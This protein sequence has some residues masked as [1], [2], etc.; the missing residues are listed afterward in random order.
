[1]TPRDLYLQEKRRAASGL[2]GVGAISIIASFCLL[3]VPLYLFQVYDRVLTS[4]S[5]ET[6]LALTVIVSVLLI[7]YGILDFIRQII[8]ARIA[9]RFETG[10]AGIV[11]AGEL[12]DE[13]G[14][15]PSILS[16]VSDIRRLMASRVFPSLF[17]LP[18]VFLFLLIVFAIHFSLGLIVLAGI[19]V[20]VVLTLLG[21]GISAGAVAKMQQSGLASRRALEDVA[22]Q[23]EVIRAMGMYRPAISA[24]GSV[25]TPHLKDSLVLQARADSV[26]AASRMARQLI[27][28]AMIGGGA[29]LVLGDEVTP[30]IIFATSVVASRALAPIEAVVGGW[31]QLRL[32]LNNLRFLERRVSQYRLA[33]ART[34]LPRPSRNIV[35]S[36]L[37]YAPH[38]G[39]RPILKGITGAVQAGQLIAVIGPS[40]AGKSTFSRILVG[41]LNPTSGQV[42]LDG[43]PL[44]AWDVEVRGAAMG[45]MPQQI[46]FFEATVRENIARLRKEDPPELAIEAAQFVGIHEMIMSFPNGYDTVI[47]EQ[48]FQ[49]SGGQKQLLGLARA[50]YGKPAFVV[51]DEPNANLDSTGETLLA[52]LLRKAKEAGIATVII[53]QR[54]SVLRQVDLVLILKDGTVDAFGPPS[55]VLPKRVVQAVPGRAS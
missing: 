26:S 12:A 55:E 42:L 34:P 51:L 48:G 19:G 44:A 37:Y 30:G 47:S 8:L 24:W 21:E 41:G 40:G 22:H 32:G 29:F 10:V 36:K 39:G 4:R 11:L 14:N 54:M 53:T 50:Y 1:M 45:Y 23:H 31:S 43:Q 16:R 6:L 46:S 15:G 5:M 33:T 38:R 20:L 28:I 13:N 49:P 2:L 3:A 17:D 27:Q 52:D 18:L 25:H 7:A 9:S 35:V